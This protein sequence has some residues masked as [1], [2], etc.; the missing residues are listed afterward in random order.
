[1]FPNTDNGSHDSV[2]YLVNNFTCGKTFTYRAHIIYIYMYICHMVEDSPG[3][4]GVF[5]GKCRHSIHNG[6]A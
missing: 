6:S 3:I 5:A 1:M 2:S 4:I